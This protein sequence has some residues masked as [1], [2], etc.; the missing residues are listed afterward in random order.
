MKILDLT[1]LLPTKILVDEPARKIQAE[2]SFGSFCLL[3]RHVDY[4]VMLVPGLFSYESDEGAKNHLAINGGTL[5]KRGF[6]VRVATQQA[7]RADTLGELREKVTGD[8]RALSERERKART[9][10]ESLQ[11][12]FVQKMFEVE[13][14]R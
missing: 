5:V 6:E 8:F 10:M 13:R 2:A 7:V 14:N 1:I 3:P 12:N 11:A 4:L 9:A